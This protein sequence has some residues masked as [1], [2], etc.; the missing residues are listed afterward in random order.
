M[1]LGAARPAPNANLVTITRI[2][3][4]LGLVDT[5]TANHQDGTE[6]AFV[7]LDHTT[8]SAT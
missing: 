8:P 4:P 5:Q 6:V 3:G 7:D 1:T 2:Y